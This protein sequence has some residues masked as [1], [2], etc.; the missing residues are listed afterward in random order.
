[1]L[2]FL[3]NIYKVDINEKWFGDSVLTIFYKKVSFG[4]PNDLSY[5]HHWIYVVMTLHLNTHMTI[6]GIKIFF[7]E[8]LKKLFATHFYHLLNHWILFKSWYSNFLIRWKFRMLKFWCLF[9]NFQWKII[10]DPLKRTGN[11]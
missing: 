10:C 2:N 9:G 1:M 7:D 3:K 11:K 5:V 8:K 6:F 4:D